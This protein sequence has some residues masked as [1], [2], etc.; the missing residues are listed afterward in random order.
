LST[1][2]W[3]IAEKTKITTGLAVEDPE[4]SKASSKTEAQHGLL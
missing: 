3:T 4:K 1:Y 2:D